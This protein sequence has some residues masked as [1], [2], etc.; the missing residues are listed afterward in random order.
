MNTEL[1][2]AMG[3]I[4]TLARLMNDD[5]AFEEGQRAAAASIVARFDEVIARIAVLEDEAADLEEGTYGK[6]LHLEDWQ[7]AAVKRIYGDEAMTIPVKFVA[8]RFVR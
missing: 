5:P 6:G 4:Y 2:K 7:I 8:G 3:E 1:T